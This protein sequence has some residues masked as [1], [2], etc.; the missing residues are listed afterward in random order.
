MLMLIRIYANNACAANTAQTDNI[1]LIHIYSIASHISPLFN[2]S[3]TSY[4]NVEN[5]VKPPQTPTFIMRTNC[6]LNDLFLP[7]T[8]LMPPIKKAPIILI[9][10]V[11]SETHW[12]YV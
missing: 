4:A 11:F 12:L 7:A 3:V 10:R 8:T 1:V 9:A 5:V 2:K 6:G